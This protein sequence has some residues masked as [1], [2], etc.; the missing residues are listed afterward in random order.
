MSEIRLEEKTSSVSLMEPDG[1]FGFR[2]VVTW[3]LPHISKIA[4]LVSVLS[5]VSIMLVSGG[6]TSKAS[7]GLEGDRDHL[8]EVQRIDREKVAETAERLASVEAAQANL[9]ILTTNMV[10]LAQEQ[11]VLTGKVDGVDANVRLVLD[12]LLRAPE[13]GTTALRRPAPAKTER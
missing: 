3:V 5:A 8:V 13:S 12:T 7:E 11:G 9:A 10:V 2:S 1:K 6:S 4:A